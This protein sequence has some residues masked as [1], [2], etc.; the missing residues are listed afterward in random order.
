MSLTNALFF[1]ETKQNVALFGGQMALFNRDMKFLFDDLRLLR[2]TG[3]PPFPCAS[4]LFLP[5]IISACWRA[6]Y[7][8]PILCGIQ[9]C[10]GAAN[11]ENA[12]AKSSPHDAHLTI[13]IVV[14]RS[15]AMCYYRDC[16]LIQRSDGECFSPPLNSW[17]QERN[18]LLTMEKQRN[19]CVNAF[20]LSLWVGWM[21]NNTGIKF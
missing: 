14:R 1:L 4:C 6:C 10:I 19:S 8:E 3:M 12:C 20:R 21:D 16:S 17:R 9:A 15:V 5:E 11:A 18:P 2:P 7:L 13:F